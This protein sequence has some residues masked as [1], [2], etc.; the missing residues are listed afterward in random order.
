MQYE[1]SI[2]RR[3]SRRFPSWCG[4]WV[5]LACGLALLSGGCRRVSEPDALA[6]LREGFSAETEA[7]AA[8]NVPTF[9][10]IIRRPDGPPMIEL[11]E[12]DPLGRVGK[13]NCSTCHSVRAPNFENR[14][15]ADLDEFHQGMEFVHGDL[16]CYSCHNPT[17]SD[18]LRRAD[19]A[20]VEYPDVM[21][22]CAQCHGNEARDYRRGAHGGMN[23]YWDLTRGGRVRNN[24]IDCHDPHAPAYPH[25]QPTFK[26]RDRFLTPPNHDGPDEKK[27]TNHHEA[28]RE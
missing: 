21:H 18:T 24:C 3:G 6:A 4:A 15:S 5:I 28:E 9:D 10:V 11:T 2:L 1:I 22:L 17:D 23:G 12:P 27:F 25:M 20:A 14:Q 7:T 26:T 19:G 16:T 8:T 13:V